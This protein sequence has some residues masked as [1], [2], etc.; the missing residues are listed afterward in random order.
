MGQGDELRSNNQ[1]YHQEKFMP[2][3]PDH[4]MDRCGVDK[5]HLEYLNA[6]KHLFKYTIHEGLSESKKKIIQRYLKE[7]GYYSYDACS[8]DEDPVSHWI[9]REV[10]RFLTEAWRHLGFLLQVAAAPPDMC[11]EMAKGLNSYEEMEMDFDDQYAPTEEEIAQEEKEEPLMLANAARW[12]RF[13]ALV[14]ASSKPWPF[15]GGA[16]CISGC[17]TNAS[18]ITEYGV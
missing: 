6:F 2:P 13:I 7:A 10:K 17:E 3:L 18:R 15:S 16:T 12:D 1:H 9:G 8:E 4:G 14:E 11:K 5:L